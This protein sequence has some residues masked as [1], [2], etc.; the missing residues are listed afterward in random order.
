MFVRE[1]QYARNVV[2]GG[3]PITRVI[4]D[5]YAPNETKAFGNRILGLAGSVGVVRRLSGLVRES[6][7][8]QC[9]CNHPFDIPMEAV[10]I[11]QSSR[12]N[13]RVANRKQGSK[14][15]REV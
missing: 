9:A 13:S 15:L 6:L 4:V 14:R 12:I 2:F 11:H 10:E 1:L 5:A 7:Q 3:I 8:P